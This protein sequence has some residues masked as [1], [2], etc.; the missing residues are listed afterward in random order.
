MSSG[1][2]FS[3]A[4]H[5]RSL[6]LCR[7]TPRR[8]KPEHEASLD[9]FVANAGERALAHTIVVFTHCKGEEALAV[10]LRDAPAPLRRWVARVHSVVGIENG[11]RA[12]LS[13][14][15]SEGRVRE[16]PSARVREL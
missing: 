6:T 7:C 9:A 4:W 12:L 11:A 1:H 2:I 10:A 14:G 15:K 8:W 16:R 5:P 3:S 13:L